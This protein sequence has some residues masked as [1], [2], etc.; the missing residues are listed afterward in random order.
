MI[1][2]ILGVLAATAA[3]GDTAGSTLTASPYGT[4]ASGDTVMLYSLRSD[5]GLIVRITNYG[6]IITALHVPDRNGQT[7]NVVL[8]KDSL[9][10]YLKGSPYFGAII[11]RYANRIAGARFVL[12]GTTCPLTANNGANTLHGGKKGFDKMVWKPEMISDHGRTA[13][14]LMSVSPDGDQGFPGN[15]TVT[16]TYELSGSQL[17]ITYEAVT[18]KPTHVNLT[19]H[20]YFNLAGTGTI[21][22][23]QLYLNASRYTPVNDQ[24]VPIGK[25]LMVSGTPF[26]FSRPTAVGTM[27]GRVPGGYDHNFVL[28]KKPGAEALAARLSDPKSGRVMEVFTTEPGIQFYAGG[29]VKNQGLCLETQHFPDSPNRPDFPSTV[30]RPGEKYVSQTSLRFSVIK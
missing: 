27:L 5:A 8:G 16:V 29:C 23:H 12:D 21:L 14:K 17:S 10:G 15:L 20:S 6:G 22:D 1:F 11:G 9:A 26:D 24:L 2:S 30:L 4:T 25:P 19:N 18:D 3:F 28:N 7:A 13:L